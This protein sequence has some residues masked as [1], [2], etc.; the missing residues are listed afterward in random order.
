MKRL[1]K[2]SSINVGDTVTIEQLGFE[3]NDIIDINNRIEAFAVIDG[4][5]YNGWDHPGIVMEY[6]EEKMESLI[7][8]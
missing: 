4:V 8:L 2:K 1:I 5:V 3:P 7:Q 6:M